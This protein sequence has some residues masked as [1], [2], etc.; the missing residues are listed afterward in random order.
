MI[1]YSF[2][3]CYEK[4]KSSVSKKESLRFAGNVREV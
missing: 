2:G 1:K 4:V 3:R